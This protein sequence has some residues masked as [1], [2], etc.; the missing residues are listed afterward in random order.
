MRRLIQF[1]LLLLLPVLSGCAHRPVKPTVQFVARHCP[2]TSETHVAMYSGHP[3]EVC[4]DKETQG[5]FEVELG[6][7]PYQDTDGDD[8]TEK[9]KP[10]KVSSWKFWVR[11]TNDKD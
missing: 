3:V 8:R 5:I 1:A 6:Y 4:V 7:N 2:D 11:R 10:H 9:Q